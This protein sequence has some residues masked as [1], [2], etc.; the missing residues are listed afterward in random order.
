MERTKSIWQ[1]PFQ[2]ARSSAAELDEDADR[3]RG[4]KPGALDRQAALLLAVQAMFAVAN[5]LSG[6]FVPVYLWKTSHSFMLIGWFTLC[7]YLISCITF[8]LAGKWVKERNKMNSLRAGIVLSGIFYLMV[9]LLG[10]QAA[11][12][13]L[14]LG[15]IQGMASGFFWLAYNVVYFEITEPDNRDRFNGWAGLLVSGS[16]MLAPWISGLLITAFAG[17][18]GYRIIFSLSLLVFVVAA[19]IS[20]FLK[21]RPIAGSYDWGHAWR[22]LRSRH[23]PWRHVF[24]ALTA[25]GMREGTFMFLVGLMVYIATTNER[26]L[27]DFTLWTSLVGLLA[28]WIIGR[29]MKPHMRRLSMLWG[30]LMIIVV[31]VPLVWKINYTTMLWFGIGTALFLPLYTIPM[32]STVF[33]LIG[34]SEESARQREEFVILREL[35]LVFGRMLSVGVYLLVMSVTTA[36]HAMAWLLLGVGSAPLAGWWLLRR[37]VGGRVPEG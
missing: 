37:Y 9:L 18:T 23:L 28:F 27:G 1:A 3:N 13:M 21:R 4:R 22:T 34:K 29:L 10:E 8:W 33:D 36:P 7:H 11:S 25:Q 31:I 32:T 19:V 30:T 6:T 26:K 15:V 16:G 12:Y 17:N 2:Q 24:L 35:G 14:L 5:A 20:F